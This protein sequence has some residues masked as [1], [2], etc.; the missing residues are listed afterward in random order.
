MLVFLV[1]AFVISLSGV[2]LPGPMFAVTVAKSYRSQ[3][4]GAQ[5][6][7][8]H[9]IIEI[10]IM[11]LIYFGFAPFFEKEVVKIALYLGGALMLFWLGFVVFKTRTRVIER[12]QDLPYNSVTAG[13]MTT[14][15]NPACILWWAI[16]GNLL[17]MKATELGT[18]AFVLLIPTHWL[19]D[20]AWLSLVS[21]IVYRTHSLMNRKIQQG[22]FIGSSLIL[23]GFGGWFLTS[24]L[25]LVL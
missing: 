16:I 22:L 20:L 6:A 14:A 18:I 25:R 24:G 3:F 8:G 11:L 19:C 17:I 15:L 12:G 7:L 10:P 21:I 5:I 13:V 9:A 23:V 2:M 1:S 4:A